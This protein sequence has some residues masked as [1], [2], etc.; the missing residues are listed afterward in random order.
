MLTRGHTKKTKIKPL[1]TGDRVYVRQVP[2]RGLSS[3]L[4]PAY[5]GPFRVLDK[6][7]DVVVKLRIIISENI[8]HCIQIEYVLCMKIMSHHT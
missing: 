1:N 2:R 4:Q 7:S 8:T 3:K 5:T 6:V